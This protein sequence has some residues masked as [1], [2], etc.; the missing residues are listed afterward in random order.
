MIWRGTP[1]PI[2]LF[3]TMMWRGEMR[4]A[5]AMIVGPT[6]KSGKPSGRL[7]TGAT[8]RLR[9]S[10]KEKR[11][12]VKTFPELVSKASFAG[13]H[14]GAGMTERRP[15]AFAGSIRRVRAP[16]SA[17]VSCSVNGVTAPIASSQSAKSQLVVK[18]KAYASCLPERDFGRFIERTK[19]S[20]K[21]DRSSQWAGESLRKRT[22][23][24]G[25]LTLPRTEK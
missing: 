19:R 22:K 6:A 24:L 15:S 5:I 2:G 23:V 14:A 17:L 12:P 8:A 10:L 21:V 3:A 11:F 9:G 1:V 13:A 20:K 16:S 7:R 18:I 25:C 4:I